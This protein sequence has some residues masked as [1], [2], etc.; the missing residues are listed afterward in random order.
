MD[1]IQHC[2]PVQNV[3]LRPTAGTG[4]GQ[5][6]SHGYALTGHHELMVPLLAAALEKQ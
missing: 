3:V 5:D 6:S 1:F 4:K 2:R